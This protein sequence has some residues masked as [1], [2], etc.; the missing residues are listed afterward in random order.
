M[1]QNLGE[2]DEAIEFAQRFFVPVFIKRDDIAP[3]TDIEQFCR[4]ASQ[5][6]SQQPLELASSKMLG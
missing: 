1:W 5:T 2:T 3:N 6:R 4:S